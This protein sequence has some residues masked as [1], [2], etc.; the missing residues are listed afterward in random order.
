MAVP[1]VASVAIANSVPFLTRSISIVSYKT[2]GQTPANVG[3]MT[4]LVSPGLFHTLG[5]RL[6]AGRDFEPADNS[7]SPGVAI[8]SSR[9][10]AALFG[11]RNPIGQEIVGPQSSAPVTVV[12]LVGDVAES[13]DGTSLPAVYMPFRQHSRR[14]MVVL[15]KSARATATL[16]APVRA[17]LAQ[18]DAGELAASVAPYMSLV[19]AGLAS[20]RAAAYVVVTM[21]IAALLLT[22]ATVN[23]VGRLR[24]AQL[25][26]DFA[27]RASV[28]A[29]PL[30]LMGRS[31]AGTAVSAGV[32]ACLGLVV[33]M[34]TT[35]VLVHLGVRVER[36][37]A[38]AIALILVLMSGAPTAG[39]AVAALRFSRRLSLASLLNRH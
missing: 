30:Q 35:G 6:I 22:T 23:I 8:L 26:R 10:A 5:I 31:A 27:I 7:S 13:L 17:A 4:R 32:G 1:H 16:E 25:E 11:Q 21:S 18:A 19:D 20:E 9:T 39:I 29:G 2:R 38:T 34:W 37:S 12:G 36:P 15:I 28:G 3:A 33:A 14:Q 24:F